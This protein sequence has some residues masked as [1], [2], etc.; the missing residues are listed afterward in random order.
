MISFRKP[1][2]LLILASLMVPLSPALAQTSGQFTMI[3]SFTYSYDQLQ[4]GGTKFMAGGLEGGQIVSSSRGALFP[5]GREF[6][7]VCAVFA[8]Q[9]SAGLNL[10]APCTFTETQEDGGDQLFT[11]A[12]RKQGDMGD[13]NRGGMGHV[14]LV[15]GTGKYADITGRCS[16]ETQYLNDRTATMMLDCNWSQ[17]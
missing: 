12:I 1:G 15:G 8:E 10:K 5:E 4:H 7:E 11:I 9:S 17:P 13:A 3:G 14:D 2:I 6:L 16:Y